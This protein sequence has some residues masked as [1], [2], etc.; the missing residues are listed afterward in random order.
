[1]YVGPLSR[2]GIKPSPTLGIVTPAPAGSAQSTRGSVP[3]DASSVTSARGRSVSELKGAGQG[4]PAPECYLAPKREA[5]G[6]RRC[7]AIPAARRAAKKQACHRPDFNKSS[8][9]EAGVELARP[10]STMRNVGEGF[11]PSRER[12]PTYIAGGD[13]PRPYVASHPQPGPYETKRIRP[14]RMRFSTDG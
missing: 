8:P 10:T 3:T 2:E 13:K 9:H 7:C 14:R 12:G 5:A 6:C 11:M 4:G 1:M